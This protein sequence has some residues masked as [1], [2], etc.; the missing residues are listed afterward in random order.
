MRVIV[1][2]YHRNRVPGGTYF[3]TVNLLDRKSDLLVRKIGLL[4]EIV[5]SVRSKKPFHIDAWVVLPD[6]LHCVWTLPQ[7]DS[8]YV[9]RWKAIKMAFS[10]QIPATESLSATQIRLNE[11]GIWQRRYWEHT[12]RDERDHAAHVD[13][14]HIN[15]VRHGWVDAVRDWPYSTFHHYVRKGVYAADWAGDVPDLET[16]EA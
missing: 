6:H 10:R 2:N 15:P 16:G 8:D 3:F 1:S 5:K 13:Y 14:C 9:S 7:G 12:I 4:R 11:R